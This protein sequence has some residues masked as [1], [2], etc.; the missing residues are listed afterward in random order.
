MQ[1]LHQEQSLLPQ[2]PYKA[3]SQDQ[4]GRGAWHPGA[5]DAG[6]A[7]SPL[8]EQTID[9]RSGK[10]L[11]TMNAPLSQPDATSLLTAAVPMYG[12]RTVNESCGR[13]LESLCAY[14]QAGAEVV[15]FPETATDSY[16]C[17]PEEYRADIQ[18]WLPELVAATARAA[19]PWVILGTYADAR[20]ANSALAHSGHQRHPLHCDHLR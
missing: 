4:L 7:A 2:H 3:S 16:P 12:T 18:R 5:G 8:K 9:R 10:E 20:H 1:V 15:V 11:V 13:I 17:R 19:G 14:A 6:C